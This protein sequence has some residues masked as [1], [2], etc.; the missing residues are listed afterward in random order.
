MCAKL[1]LL[2]FSRKDARPIE[3]YEA[4]TSRAGKM[5]VAAVTL[6]ETA[7][8][9]RK[10]RPREWRFPEKERKKGTE[11]EKVLLAREKSFDIAPREV[12]ISSHYRNRML[13]YDNRSAI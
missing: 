7:R 8:T 2:N 3:F 13:K 6:R 4:C 10:S 12:R 9:P 1:P 5:I 11:M